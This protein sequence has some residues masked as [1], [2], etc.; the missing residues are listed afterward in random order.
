MNKPAEKQYTLSVKSS[1]GD[2][3]Y[4]SVKTSK[5]LLYGNL[6][7]S[8]TGKARSARL[9]LRIVYNGKK[10]RSIRQIIAKRRSSINF[11]YKLFP[12]EPILIISS[13]HSLNPNNL[14]INLKTPRPFIAGFCCTDIVL[15]LVLDLPLRRDVYTKVKLATK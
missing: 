6:V 3:G 7:F 8:G 11:Q 13:K 15:S 1:Y 12:E 2:T 5:D 4:A 9:E 10:A 14:I